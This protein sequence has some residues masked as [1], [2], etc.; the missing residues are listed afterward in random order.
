MKIPFGLHVYMA[1][2]SILICQTPVFS[3]QVPQ[4]NGAASLLQ[5]AGTPESGMA[6]TLSP[7]TLTV[8]PAAG[9]STFLLSSNCNAWT[10]SWAPSWLTVTPS[11]GSNNATITLQYQQNL[12]PNPRTAVL[13]VTGCNMTAT[14]TLTQNGTGPACPTPTNL[15]ATYIHYSVFSLKWDSMPAALRYQTRARLAGSN[16]W[17]TGNWG[18]VNKADWFNVLPNALYECQV[19][20]S[21]ASGLGAWS[22]TYTLN[23]LGASDPY[24]YSFGTSTTEWINVVQYG[25]VNN[26]SG[27]NLGYRNYTNLS[28]NVEQGQSF[29]LNITPGTNNG[30]H[31]VNWRI[32]IDLNKDND[33]LD[34]NEALVTTPG[35][36]QTTLSVA[37]PIPLTAALGPTRMRIMMGP[38]NIMGPC[39]LGN[40]FW[41]VE[42]YTV[43]ITTATTLNVNPDTFTV[44]ASA[45]VATMNISSNCSSWTIANL[46]SWITANP[47]SGNGSISVSLNYQQNNSVNPRSVTFDVVGCNISRKVTVFQSGSSPVITVSPSTF[48]LPTASGWSVFNVQS[49]CSSW[50]ITGAP[51]WLTLTPS[52]G[53][54]NGTIVMQYLQNTGPARSATLTVSGCNIN[55]TITVTQAGVV[56]TL[57]VSTTGLSFTE[58]SGN[59]GFSITTNCANWTITGAP[60]WV[61]LSATSGGNNATISLSYTA[62]TSPVIRYG[63]LTISGCNLTQT[64]QL[65]QNAAPLV[66]NAAPNSL[67]V[68]SDAGTFSFGLQSNCPAW[69][70]SGAPAWLTVTPATGGQNGNIVLLC[71]QNAEAIP[72]SATLTINACGGVQTFVLNQSGAPISLTVAPSALD[73]AAAG[74]TQL[75]N[76]NVNCGWIVASAPAWI[77]VTPVAGAGSEVLTVT[78]VPNTDF[79]PRY[80]TLVLSACN[81]L[82]TQNIPLVQ[83]GIMPP[84]QPW[85]VDSTSENHTIIV[86][87]DISADFLGNPLENGDRIG[88]FYDSLGVLRCAGY[89]VWNGAT[90]AFT[91]YGNDANA[92]AENGFQF[93]EVFNLRI[94]RNNSNQVLDALATFKPVG[95]GGIVSHTDRYAADGISMLA[96]VSAITSVSNTITLSS[97]WNLISSHVVPKTPDMLQVFNAISDSVIIVKNDLGTSTIPS[98]FLNNIGNWDVKEGYQVKTQNAVSLQILGDKVAP[99]N[100]PIPLQPGWQIIAYLRDKPQDAAE[101]FAGVLND[102]EIVKDNAGKSFI[103]Q[104]NINTI[105]LMYP[106][107][108]YKVKAIGATALTYAA[109]FTGS[110]TDARPENA[111]L[112]QHFMLDSLNTGNNA[113]LVIPAAVAA[114][115]LSVGDEVGVF[116]PGGALCGAAIF[117]G[118]N[119]AVTVWGDDATTQDVQEGML[120]G[121]AYQI[122]AWKAAN[123]L[124]YTTAATYNGSDGL[125]QT[126]DLEVLATWQLLST[127]IDD[128]ADHCDLTVYPNP[129][130]DYFVLNLD[131]A[132]ETAARIELLHIDGRLISVW[133]NNLNAGKQGLRFPLNKQCSA[134]S[135]VLR[136]HTAD[137]LIVHRLMVQP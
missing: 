136:V 9:F 47:S 134:G 127:G 51:A 29:P 10:I 102:I 94:W 99:Q 70:I 122:H 60:A 128:E 90:T 76:L 96:S 39:N 117:A 19:R 22:S 72:R 27:N 20:D 4:N 35:N 110:S 42:D 130:T 100:L 98:L 133:E 78:A 17:L 66:L 123:Q 16:T 89:M 74:D 92:P 3:Q 59:S 87:L 116:T 95:T 88:V 2:L 43:N 119:L 112:L 53:A 113:T 50:T 118:S 137:E 52:S 106:G 61:N 40:G 18:T 124:E 86:P 48:T 5:K 63:T 79:D 64:I 73:F 67:N 71:E 23:T 104:F 114:T 111:V 81:G 115:V 14:F 135:Y 108:G 38:S 101:V 26:V 120:P 121:E 54:N 28:A 65:S 103:P 97:G 77:A 62:N 126:D 68:G 85:I 34:A 84:P 37:V 21:C 36:D 83:A 75:L 105:G 93:N 33:F 15:T 46:P 6:F 11:S 13:T 58:E 8:G 7:S 129:A 49:N 107:R 44:N 57:S 109:N 45:G 24:C 12:T 32:W 31:S 25:T 41:D 91:V 131:C 56:P 125:Y 132:Q 30:T 80:D 1:F 69:T 82:A 55:K